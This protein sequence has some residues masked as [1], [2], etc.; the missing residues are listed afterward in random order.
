MRRAMAEAEVGDDV[1]G[2]DPTVNK[3]E[4]LAAQML[5]K[6]SAV[7]VPSGTMANGV[8]MV[9]QLRRGDEVILGARTHMYLGEQAALAVLSQAQAVPIMENPDGTLPLDL[10]EDSI[11][12]PDPHHPITR[13]VCIENTHN[14]CGGQ[15]LTVEY[16]NQVGALAKKHDLRF[17]ID[18]ARLFNAAVALNVNVADLVRA[19]DTVSFCL[20]KGLCAP[21]GSLV[22]GD[23]ETIASARRARKLLGGGMRQAGIIAAAGIVSLTSMIERLENDHDE[24][25]T[26]MV[27]F[28]LA[29]STKLDASQLTTKL[30]EKG[31][32]VGAVGARRIRAVLHYWISPVQ[33]DRVVEVIKE[34]MK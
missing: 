10:I 25:R 9:A 2:D 12:T 33:V 30:K 1:F 3:L 22:C 14:A 11:R 13:M 15:P 23:K 29:P 34:V 26:N 24:V 32:L 21:I 6:E 20:S 5:E 7:F 4:S 19:A 16:T 18:G 27:Y 31:I 17:H 28:D 8:A